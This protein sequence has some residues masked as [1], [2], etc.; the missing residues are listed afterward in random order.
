MK[1]YDVE[2]TPAKLYYCGSPP[3]KDFIE[4]NGIVHVNSYINKRTERTI[5]IFIMTDE[6]SNLLTIWSNNRDKKGV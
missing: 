2:K 3:L 1:I 4:N 5:W 6:L